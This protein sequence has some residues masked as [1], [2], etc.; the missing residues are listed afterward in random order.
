MRDQ[1]ARSEARQQVNKAVANSPGLSTLGIDGRLVRFS[2]IDSAAIEISHG[3]YGSS[4]PW[5][6]VPRWKRKDAKGLDLA[7]WH[8][9]ELCGL[10]YATPR[11]SHLRIK[12]ILLE[13]QPNMRHPLKGL[14]AR[15]MF[16]AVG[17]YARMLGCEVIQIESPEPGVVSYYQRLGFQ[18]DADGCLVI[19]AGRS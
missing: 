17:V 19:S 7:L 6:D 16:L 3:W 4:Y 9:D 2:P 12:V 15:L 11:R 13:G 10:C 1:I 8:A 5:G 18:F 14:V